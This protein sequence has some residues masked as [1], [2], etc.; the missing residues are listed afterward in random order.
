MGYKGLEEIYWGLAIEQIKEPFAENECFDAYYLHFW[1][2]LWKGLGIAAKKKEIDIPGLSQR[3]KDS[4]YDHL[5]RISLRTLI[6]EMELC[7][8]CGE[9]SGED[10]HEQY[11]YYANILLQSP[12]FLREIYEEYPFMYKGLLETVYHLI[13]NIVEVAER[14]D[15][16][17]NEIN[18][19]FYP[20]HPCSRILQIDCSGSD[21]HRGGHKVFFLELDNKERLVYKPRNLAVDEAYLF[22]LKGVFLKIGMPFWWNGILNRQKYGWC[23]WVSAQDCTSC[24]ELRRYYKRNGILLCV[25]YLLGSEDMHYENLIAHGEYPVLVDLEMVVGGRG[26]EKKEKITDVEKIFRESVYHIGIL[27]LYAW[28]E[29]GEGV[30]VGAI[31]GKGGQ[32]V[33]FVMPVV[34]KP[35]TVKM[36]IEYRHHKMSE[37]KN[38]AK[39]NGSFI[40]PCELTNEILEGFEEAYRLFMERQ[41]WVFEKLEEFKDV[42]VRYLLRNS[43]Q[44]MMALVTLGHPNYLFKDRSLDEIWEALGGGVKVLESGKDDQRTG[45]K[46]QETGRWLLK[47]EIRD[48]LQWDIPYFYANVSECGLYSSK[49]EPLK[50]FFPYP[51]MDS[52]K[53]RLRNLCETDLQ[54]QKRF[55][56]ASLM[57]GKRSTAS[58]TSWEKLKDEASRMKIAERIGNHLLEEAVWTE[59]RK[60]IGWISVTMTGYQERSYLVRPMNAYL[61]DGLSGMTLFFAELAAKTGRQKFY[62]TRDALVKMLF[63][64]TDELYAKKTLKKLP[65]GAYTGEASV[66][67]AYMLLNLELSD[68]VYMTY[69]EKQCQVTRRVLADD[70][71]YDILGGNAGAIMV[72]LNAYT[73]TGQKKFLIWAE[74]A[75]DCLLKSASV[76]PWGI[77]WINPGIGKALTG[78]AHGT[79]GMMLALAR[80]GHESKKDKYMEA[81][82]QAYRYEEHYY[83]GTWQDWADLRYPEN[84]LEKCGQLAWCHGWG[85][86][87]VARLLSF[88]YARGELKKELGEI[89]AWIQLKRGISYSERKMCLCHGKIGNAAL[90]AFMGKKEEAEGL[91]VQINRMINNEND[92]CEG[93]DTQECSNYGLLNGLAGIGYGCLCGHNNVMNILSVGDC[94]QER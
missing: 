40:E 62:E 42:S 59:D 46:V 29:M 8:E 38:L 82:Y 6:F 54:M 50:D 24:E 37:G 7:A 49:G 4:F 77:G 63:L 27:P 10:C 74:E 71:N 53:R 45:S 72:F 81:A 9:L 85:G 84:S 80:L 66:A 88:K 16:D 18:S 73:I 28:N 67:F 93:L 31:N 5:R 21:D 57:P 78:F 75:G 91:Q 58:Q 56:L 23:Q 52:V 89:K 68:P 76:F 64:H 12:K 69:L 19:S 41:V 92:L 14:F 94:L 33:P 26:I 20:D 65:T 3:L 44:Y 25:S 1:E 51:I 83:S 35:G 61:Y 11:L 13:Q 36:H 30:N 87:I 34:V 47:Q 2:T 86:I 79:A 32:S 22:F 55:I 60:E 90:L 48:L 15:S 39:L 70:V 43:Q 17:R